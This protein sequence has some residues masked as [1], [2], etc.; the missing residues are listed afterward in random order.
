[1]KMPLGL[2]MPLSLCDTLRDIL[3]RRISSRPTPLVYLIRTESASRTKFASRIEF[4]NRTES[5]MNSH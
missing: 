2:A 4:A 5:A 1:M 3:R